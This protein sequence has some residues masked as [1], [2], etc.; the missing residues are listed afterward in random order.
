MSNRILLPH[1][2]SSGGLTNIATYLHPFGNFEW[3]ES[4]D[5]YAPS[6]NFLN[7]AEGLFEFP[8]TEIFRGGVLEWTR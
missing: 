1:S 4:R 5:G 6:I 7:N 8:I 2:T 3:T